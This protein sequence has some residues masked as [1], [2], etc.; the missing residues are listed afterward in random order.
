VETVTFHNRREM[1]MLDEES[2]LVIDLKGKSWPARNIS[3]VFGQ[4]AYNYHL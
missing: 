2:T 1:Y 4:N 3:S